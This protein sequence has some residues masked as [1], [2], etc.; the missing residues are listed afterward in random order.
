MRGRSR[1]QVVTTNCKRCGKSLAMTNRSIYGADEA[2]ATY[3]RICSDCI[4][5]GEYKDM[6]KAQAGAILGSDLSN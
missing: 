1:I 6:L 2:K 4:T 5:P 3:E